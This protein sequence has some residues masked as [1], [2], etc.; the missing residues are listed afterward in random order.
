MNFQALMSHLV[1]M[2]APGPLKQ[3]MLYN[4]AIKRSEPKMII[5][6]STQLTKMWFRVLICLQ[7]DTDCLILLT[8]E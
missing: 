3:H 6:C 4:R 5:V 1:F 7:S 2:E 8:H